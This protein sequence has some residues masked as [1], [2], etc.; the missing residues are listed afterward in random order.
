[1]EDNQRA[2]SVRSDGGWPRA[3]GETEDI[4]RRRP[5]FA[6]KR[7]RF[8]SFQADRPEV[9]KLNP[10]ISIEKDIARFH[11]PVQ[12]SEAMRKAKSKRNSHNRFRFRRRHPPPTGI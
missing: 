7:F 10:P 12:Q 6:R 4:R 9:R 11:R 3:S 1:M 5:L 2:E 8:T